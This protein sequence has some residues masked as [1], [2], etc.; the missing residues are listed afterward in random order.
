MLKYI[1]KRIMVGILT[2]FVLVV[3]TFTMTKLM[4]GSPLQSKNITGE[5]LERMEAQYGLDKPPVEQFFIY[6]KNLLHGDMGTS[7][8]K[9][10]TKVSDI[11]SQTMVTTLRLGL[12]TFLL[13]LVVGIT[14]G[15]LM[16]RSKSNTIKG[17]WLSGLTL[18]VSVPNFIV[19]LLLLII[20]GVQLRLFPVLGLSTPLHYVLPAIA[21]GLYPISAVAR[22]TQSSYEEVVKQDYITMAKA[23]GISSK[24][25][26]FRHILKNAMLP[27]ITYM[28]PMVAFL[29]TGSVVIEQIYTIPGIGKEFV[30]AITNHDFT[31]VMGITIFIGAIIIVC[32]LVADLICA[33]VDPRI[34]KSL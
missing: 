10:G 28:G 25:L 5:V 11:I 26:L 8:K 34:R 27:V 21:Q 4:P 14:S 15:I 6:C 3:I 19:A 12:V 31:L 29:L 16:A 30:N 23:K 9:V 17:I 20:F 13:V 24:T 22:L 7:Y 1:V 18:G 2:L 33:I 32:N